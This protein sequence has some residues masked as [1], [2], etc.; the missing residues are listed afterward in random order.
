MDI[1]RN[2]NC[3]CGSNLKYKKCCQNNFN[4]T[5]KKEKLIESICDIDA[6]LNLLMCDLDEGLHG[7][8]YDY[9][10]SNFYNFLERSDKEIEAILEEGWGSQLYCEWILL[11][12][13]F[14]NMS[15]ID[16]VIDSKKTNVEGFDKSFLQSISD[17]KMSF[18]EM[19]EIKEGYLILKDLLFCEIHFIKL[20]DDDLFEK[21]RVISGRVINTSDGKILLSAFTTIS[22][23]SILKPLQVLAIS[24]SNDLEDKQMKEAELLMQLEILK[25]LVCG[26]ESKKMVLL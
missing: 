19:L 12:A 26:F 17:T 4:N 16:W 11:T 14:E 15:L 10:V 7:E 24:L 9:A 21:N 25:T 18:F 23:L 8:Y 13:K 6:I 2:S 22:D 5:H 1:P 3:P 20:L